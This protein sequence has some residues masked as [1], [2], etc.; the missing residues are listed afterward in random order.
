MSLFFGT[1]GLRGKLNDNL[2]ASVAFKCGNALGSVYPNSKI[3][4]G[5]DTR[6]T[7]SF[8]SLAFAVGTMQAGLNVTSVGVCPTAGIAY[9][10]NKLGFDFGI[11]ISA[12]HNPAEFNG[13]K[14]IDKSGKK[15]DVQKETEIER[16]FLKQ[17]T[18]P[19]KQIGEYHHK[20]QLIKLYKK[21]LMEQIDCVLN[22]KTI[23]LDCSNGAA[24]KIAPQ[25][26]KNHGAKVIKISCKPNGLNINK[27]CGSLYVQKLKQTVLKYGADMGFA[28]D[29]DSDRVIA[30][31][32]KGSVIDGDQLMYMFACFY[33]EHNKLTRSVVV[34]TTMTNKGVE[35]ALN[36][37]GISLIRTDVGDKYIN[38][39][40]E[41]NNLLIGGEQSGHI[42]VKDKLMTGD[43]ILN[44]LLV[45]YICE[46]S[47]KK[48]SE[49]FDF[50]LHNQCM[51]NIPVK[52]KMKI[53]SSKKLLLCKE[54]EEKKL[55]NS[56]RI[57]VR[58]SGTEPCVRVMVETET[59]QK[60]KEIAD[61]IAK[62]VC[63]INSEN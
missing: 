46:K 28:F 14:I 9:L 27:N 33:Q 51:L 5:L 40:L 63:E 30:V 43:G 41:Q 52:N 54:T 53:I 39:K 19:F 61:K 36:K 8:L 47:N 35:N 17:K 31:D 48:L 42:F 25:V 2:S 44:A 24:S 60:S 57:L 55:A 29:G 59:E 12:S 1:D 7:S 50:S 4:I 32:E 49:F 23:V 3:L 45:A 13:I 20:P 34:G 16:E 6:K 58:A 22:K 10:T 26:F 38:E 15:L 18:V 56:G 62:V 37:K 21:F 11:V